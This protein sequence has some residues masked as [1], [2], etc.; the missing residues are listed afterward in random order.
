[1]SIKNMFFLV[2]LLENNGYEGPR[3]FDAHAYRT[4][5]EQGVWDFASGCMR[6]YNMFKEKAARF[7]ADPEVQQ[8]LAAVNSSTPEVDALLTGGYSEARVQQLREATF[9]VDTLASRGYGYERLDQIAV[10]HILGV[11]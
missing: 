1:E 7:D 6:T 3:H 5:D 9:D 10:E 11:R 8:I 2:R 4:E